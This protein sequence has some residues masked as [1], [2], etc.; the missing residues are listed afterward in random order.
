MLHCDWTT[1]Q[2]TT[3]NAAVIGQVLRVGV[4]TTLT[5]KTATNFLW[6]DVSVCCANRSFWE[7]HLSTATCSVLDILKTEDSSRIKFEMDITLN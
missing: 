3:A 4:F 6:P 1:I 5:L 7:A 2:N